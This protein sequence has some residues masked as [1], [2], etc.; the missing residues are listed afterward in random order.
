MANVFDKNFAGL[1]KETV[2]DKITEGLD[3]KAPLVPLGGSLVA[4]YVS[5]SS[6]YD[7]KQALDRS[8]LGRVTNMLKR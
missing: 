3:T 7:G 2:S 4:S 5:V 6:I 8:V 1:N